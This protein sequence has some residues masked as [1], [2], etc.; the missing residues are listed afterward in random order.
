MVLNQN[1]ENNLKK[2]EKIEKIK[3]FFSKIFPT[4]NEE[5]K[6]V[7]FFTNYEKK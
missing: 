5:H 1:F 4:R 7:L 6:S 3:K 2:N